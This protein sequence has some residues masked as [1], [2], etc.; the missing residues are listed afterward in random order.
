MLQN[1]KTKIGTKLKN[2]N[3]NKT[4]K[5]ELGQNSTESLTNFQISNF[6]EIQQLKL[7]Q[8][9]TTQ[10]VTKLKNSNCDKTQ[11]LRVTDKSFVK[12]N[13]TPQQPMRCIRG[14]HL[15]SRDFF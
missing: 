2:L 6:D 7:R 12:N 15:R 3:C 1:S 14:S 8:N 13:L 11:Q 10:N 4:Q 9:S 5:L